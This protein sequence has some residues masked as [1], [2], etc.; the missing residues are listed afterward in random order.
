MLLT[1]KVGHVWSL[2]I[3]SLGDEMFIIYIHA[4]VLLLRCLL[5]DVVTLVK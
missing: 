5:D 4:Y 1:S 3:P 2:R